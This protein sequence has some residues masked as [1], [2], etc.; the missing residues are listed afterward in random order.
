MVEMPK[1]AVAMTHR[2]PLKLLATIACLGSAASADV[3]HVP[4]DY[5]TIQQAI[6]AA[7][8]GDEIIVSR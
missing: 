2:A 4:D 6:D 7:V 5:P 1:E 3:I 8:D